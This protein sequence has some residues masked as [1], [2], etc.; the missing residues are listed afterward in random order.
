MEPGDQREEDDLPGPRGGAEIRQWRE[1]LWM[2]TQVVAELRLAAQGLCSCICWLIIVARDAHRSGVEAAREERERGAAP[3]GPR[4]RRWPN[5]GCVALFVALM[6]DLLAGTNLEGNCTTVGAGGTGPGAAR[7]TGP[8]AW[9]PTGELLLWSS[10]SE[11]WEHVLVTAEGDEDSEELERAEERAGGED[12]RRRR[13]GADAKPRAQANEVRR[14]RKKG[15]QLAAESHVQPAARHD[16]NRTLEESLAV[17]ELVKEQV[18]EE[19]QET[20]ARGTMTLYKNHWERWAWFCL[21][22]GLLS[23]LLT[24]KTDAE[25]IADEDVVLTWVG[26]LRYLQKAGGTIKTA[27]YAV[28]AGH[29]RVGAG[30][31]FDGMHR[32]WKLLEKYA[33]EGASGLRRLGVTPSMLEEMKKEMKPQTPAEWRAR[34]GGRNLT[35]ANAAVRWAA[36]ATAY[37]FM[38]RPGEVVSS[39]GVDAERILRGRDVAL[40]DA[41]GKEDRGPVERFDLTFRKT[42]T[43]QEAFG[44]TRSHYQTGGSLCPVEAMKGLKAWFPERFGKGREAYLPVFRWSS[45]AV[46]TRE[47]L[48][49][50]LGA[51]AKAVGLPAE[52]FTAHSFRIGGASALYNATGEIETVKRYGRWTS[53]AF[54]RYLWDSADQAKGVAAKMAVGAATVHRS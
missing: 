25:R 18:S 22:W 51:A 11:F 29:K 31:P 35:Q 42:K 36:T 32:L 26:Y 23:P 12:Q 38:P 40:L 3:A 1:A 9:Q 4:E 28:A 15:E 37:F 52:R 6:L 2:S 19:L 54:H 17:G 48:Q 16:L 47:E 30:D 50:P 20:G 34:P 46:M 41:E 53:G 5:W 7:G 33:K 49:E 27:V 14:S 13:K 44:A 39:G 10:N 45:G 8:G 21:C 43:D 24:G